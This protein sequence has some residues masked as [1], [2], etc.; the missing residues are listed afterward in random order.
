MEPSSAQ[1]SLPYLKGYSPNIVGQIARLINEKRLG[2]FLVKRYPERHD[3]RNN[4]AL[5]DYVQGLKSRYLKQSPPISKAVYDDKIH[6]VNQALGLHTQISRVQGGK[7]KTKNEIRIGTM[8]RDAPPALLR[9]ICVHELAHLREKEHNKAF[10]K[11][12]TYMEPDYH[13]LEFD[14]RVYLTHNELFG[15]IYSS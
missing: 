10:Y 3:I 6:I 2:E 14:T 15:S 11:L 9:M 12:C 7:L 8:F 4:K 1:P 5:Y 13:Q